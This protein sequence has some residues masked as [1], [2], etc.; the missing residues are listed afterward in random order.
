VIPS[1]EEYENLSE[2]SASRIAKPPHNLNA[3]ERIGRFMADGQQAHSNGGTDERTR[4]LL[5]NN[6]TQLFPAE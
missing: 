3:G 1:R 6:R 4:G 5:F 2:V